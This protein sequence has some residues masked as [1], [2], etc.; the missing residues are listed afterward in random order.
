MGIL[1]PVGQHADG[2]GPRGAA[3]ARIAGEGIDHEC[4]GYHM[5]F[6]T[7]AGSDALVTA[8]SPLTSGRPVLVTVIV[9]KTPRNEPDVVRRA[10]TARCG[11]LRPARVCATGR[12][13]LGRRSACS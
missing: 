11:Q 12:D 7:G 8:A 10:E 3:L 4:V 6:L 5:S 1:A 2:P 13:G 9:T